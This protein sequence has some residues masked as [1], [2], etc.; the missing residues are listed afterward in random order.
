MVKWKQRRG[1]RISFPFPRYPFPF[2]PRSSPFHT[3]LFRR[4]DLGLLFTHRERFAEE[5]PFDVI[6]EEI[7]S[8]GTGEIQAVVIDDLS[9]LL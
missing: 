4:V 5:K 3:A 6:E 1:K 9:L 2:F 8:V 7:L